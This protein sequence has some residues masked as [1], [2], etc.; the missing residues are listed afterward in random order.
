MFRRSS[1]TISG[2]AVVLV[3]QAVW[4]PGRGQA[5][6]REDV[7]AQLQQE[8]RE[9]RQMLIQAMQI[10]QQHHDLLLKLI[11][12]GDK[13][14]AGPRLPSSRPATPAQALAGEATE[15]RSPARAAS[16]TGRV[17][18]TG[19]PPGQPIFVFIEDLRG[20]PA[21]G[22]TVEIVQEGK[23]FSPQ[24][25]VVPVGTRAIFPNKDPVFHN[26]FSLSRGNAFDVS[27]KAGDRGSPVVLGRPGLVEVYC[28]IHSRM[29]AEILVTRNGHITRVGPDGKFTLDDVPVGERVVAAWTAGT[30]P[31]KRTVQL[32]GSG[33]R[34]D[35]SLKVSPRRAH[36]NK[37]GQPYGSYE[38]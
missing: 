9:L 31:V 14:A 17:E 10:E 27:V 24:V 37:L 6:S 1:S 36:N 23:Q 18:T 26:A 13:N 5:Q 22:P 4:L 30:T 2:A 25:S 34:V 7:I 15:A 33:A 19:A 12:S 32:G 28:D 16:V 11:Q 29:W 38:E 20:P 8:V 35:F 3:L 21:R